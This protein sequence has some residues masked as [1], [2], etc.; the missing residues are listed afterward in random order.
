MDWSPSTMRSAY[1]LQPES[2]VADRFA[3]YQPWQIMARRR[4]DRLWHLAFLSP[5]RACVEARLVAQELAAVLPPAA[6][7]EAR[8]RGLIASAACWEDHPDRLG[9]DP[10]ARAFPRL[11]GSFADSAAAALDLDSE[12][13][14]PVPAFAPPPAVA[15][16]AGRFPWAPVADDLPEAAIVCAEPVS[17]SEPPSVQTV[18]VEGPGEADLA[19]GSSAAPGVP[20]MAP[21]RVAFDGDVGANRPLV[22]EAAVPSVPCADPGLLPTVHAISCT[23]LAENPPPRPRKRASHTRRRL[24][25]NLMPNRPSL[26]FRWKDA[27]VSCVG[28]LTIYALVWTV[29]VHP[30][31]VESRLVPVDGSGRPDL[32]QIGAEIALLTSNPVLQAAR[33]KA[34]DLHTT[35]VNGTIVLQVAGTGR[36]DVE[37]VERLLRTYQE[38]RP[39]VFGVNHSGNKLSEMEQALSRTEGELTAIKT[40]SPTVGLPGFRDGL[41][42]KLQE[43]ELEQATLE[44]QVAGLEARSAA[45][46]KQIGS[47]PETVTVHQDFGRASAADQ[48]R[49]SISTLEIKRAE[50]LRAY[51]P[52]A[53]PVVE[54]DGQIASLRRSLNR[55]SGMQVNQERRG[56]NEGRDR[57]ETE[58]ALV[59]AEMAST[60]SKLAAVI[61]RV[62][63]LRQELA[64]VAAAEDAYNRLERQAARLRDEISAEQTA[65]ARIP[66]M[67]S[68][69][70][71]QAP[72]LVGQ[73][74]PLFDPIPAGAA[75]LFLLLWLGLRQVVR[76]RRKTQDQPQDDQNSASDTPERPQT[77]EGGNPLLSQDVEKSQVLLT[78]TLRRDLIGLPGQHLARDDGR[79]APLKTFAKH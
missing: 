11:A 27:A 63:A 47:L 66:P 60:R 67:A 32:A 20:A 8:L 52:N 76:S 28:A 43:A 4:L 56:R 46:A 64:S 22:A 61:V 31:A 16:T 69:R 59:V 54:I 71:V 23:S 37:R 6:T 40:A 7:L 42:F 29:L 3:V 10:L 49:M 65:L 44:S 73:P 34:D 1:R 68:I 35:T 36:A 12:P 50:L 38:A 55:V 13:S 53:R 21:E 70:M 26:S 15:R 62:G 25:V 17:P 79:L 19:A 78:L 39:G 33:V 45:L 77:R 24:V 30:M 74:R 58:N 72:T 57:M 18:A 48:F 5:R 14:A 41:G 75:G 9:Q 51:L 2:A